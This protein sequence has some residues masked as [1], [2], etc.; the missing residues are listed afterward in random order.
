MK[1]RIN[2]LFQVCVGWSGGGVRIQ[3]IFGCESEILV[4]LINYVHS[5]AA[6]YV[7]TGISA[8]DQS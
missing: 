1:R 3:S 5:Q 2:D 8:E 6:S 4:W 7:G